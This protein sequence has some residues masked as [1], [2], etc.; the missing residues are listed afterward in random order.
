MSKKLKVIAV[1]PAYN[2]ARTL[3][4]TYRDIPVGTVSEVLVV[5][6]GSRDATVRVARRLGLKVVVH[7]RNRGYGGNQKTCYTLALSQGADVVVM[8]HPD[9]QYDSALTGE[10]VRPI[11]QGRF[12]IMLGSRIRTRAES[13]KGGMPLYKYFSNRFLTLLENLVL[14]QNLSEYHTGFRAYSRQI[15]SRLPFHRYSDDFVFD[16]QI[17]LGAIAAGAR[18]GEI[19]VPVRYF[20]EAS[21][22]NFRHAAVY[23]LSILRD[24]T[25]HLLTSGKRFLR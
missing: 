9:Y 4:K 16:Q 5:D 1:M 19:P 2:A 21:S 8:I 22:I 6:D 17:L 12:D 23:G 13:A 7:P 3:T 10:L 15:L 25:L 20:P 24:L 18:I 14:G 11:L